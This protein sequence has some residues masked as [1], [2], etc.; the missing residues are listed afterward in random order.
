MCVCVW[1]VFKANFSLRCRG[2]GTRTYDNF[3]GP[4]KCLIAFLWLAKKFIRGFP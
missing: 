1:Y 2:H 3:R 4:Y